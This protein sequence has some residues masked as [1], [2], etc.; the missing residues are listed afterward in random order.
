MVGTLHHG[1]KFRDQSAS[2][3]I[4]ANF[5]DF[6]WLSSSPSLS[7]PFIR[8]TLAPSNYF[9]SL[10]TIFSS[11]A[12]SFP[13]PFIPHSL[14]MTFSSSTILTH[15]PASIVLPPLLLERTPLFSIPDPVGCDALDTTAL[16]SST[17]VRTTNRPSF[18]YFQKEFIL[19]K[20]P[21]RA[22][23]GNGSARSADGTRKSERAGHKIRVH[24][25]IY[26][27]PRSV[28]TGNRR[29]RGMR[30]ENAAPC[31]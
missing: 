18:K 14:R 3:R 28:A 16:S 24:G 11:A 27:V 15:L 12:R 22:S 8:L 31:G 25:C 6:M 30:D 21:R 17:R 20:Y 5:K 9:R 19:R 7:P 23:P 10:N 29:T 13:F 4:E 1:H 26:E 2:R